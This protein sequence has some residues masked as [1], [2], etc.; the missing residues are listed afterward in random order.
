MPVRRLVFEKVS[1]WSGIPDL[2]DPNARASR[3]FYCRLHMH[4]QPFACMYRRELFPIEH[5]ELKVDDKQRGMG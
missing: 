5:T 3:A 1:R 4:Q 2:D